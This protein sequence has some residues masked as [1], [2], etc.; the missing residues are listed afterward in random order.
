MTQVGD[1]QKIETL[2]D[3][4][5]RGQWKACIRMHGIYATFAE[6]EVIAVRGGAS[7][8]DCVRKSTLPGAVGD[9][10]P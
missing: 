6:L 4:L 9:E 7:L 2:T 8:K 5:N 10:E 1:T 3:V